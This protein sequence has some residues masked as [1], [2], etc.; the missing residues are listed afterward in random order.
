MPTDYRIGL[1]IYQLFDYLHSVYVVYDRIQHLSRLDRFT[2]LPV[3]LIQVI[4]S[5]GLG[6]IL[7]IMN[8]F[9]RDVG[10]FVTILLQF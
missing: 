8:V 6:M 4:F 9:V 2:I 5:V 3:L 7:A 1:I 10:Q